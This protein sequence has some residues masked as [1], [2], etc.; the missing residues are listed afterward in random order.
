MLRFPIF[1]AVLTEKLIS[2][3]DNCIARAAISTDFLDPTV[4]K[5]WGIRPKQP[6]ILELR[7]HLENFQSQVRLTLILFNS[8]SLLA[9]LCIRAIIPI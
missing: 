8:F 3:E 7:F 2:D 9:F 4:A 1:L 6:I 5:V